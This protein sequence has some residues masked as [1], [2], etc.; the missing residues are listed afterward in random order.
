MGRLD[1]L[2]ESLEYAVGTSSGEDKTKLLELRAAVSG[3]R[4]D[5]YQQVQQDRF[6]SVVQSGRQLGETDRLIKEFYD[7]QSTS[8]YQYDDLIGRIKDRSLRATGVE[9]QELDQLLNL[10]NFESN[11]ITRARDVASNNA[12]ANTGLDLIK[13]LSPEAAENLDASLTVARENTEKNRAVLGANHDRFRQLVQ[14]A[15][16]FHQK[17]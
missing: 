4:K 14:S 16:I 17:A 7:N 5:A 6:T 10:A 3:Y 15:G 12:T 13:A 8:G 2:T 11:Q 9:K 1:S